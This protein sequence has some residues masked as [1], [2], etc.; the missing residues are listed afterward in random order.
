MQRFEESF[1]KR[2]LILIRFTPIIFVLSFCIMSV[3]NRDLKAIPLLIGLYIVN[4]LLKFFGDGNVRADNEGETT[5][6]NCFIYSDN[7]DANGISHA[8][9]G[10]ILTYVLLPMIYNDNYNILI[11][12]ILLSSYFLDIYNKVFTEGCYGSRKDYAI[13]TVVIASIFGIAVAS[14]MFFFLKFYDDPMIDN[15]L[16]YNVSQYNKVQCLRNSEITYT[17][18]SQ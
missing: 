10:Y 17:C 13:M 18:E 12:V 4:F 16:Y 14:F 5:K 9:M 7:E 11:L 6:V 3:F 2:I 8:I 15:L 1:S